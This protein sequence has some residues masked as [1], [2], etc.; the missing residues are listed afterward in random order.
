MQTD[1]S[2][3]KSK[4]DTEHRKA[5]ESHHE[6]RTKENHHE[7]K[8]S[9]KADEGHDKADRK[10]PKEHSTRDSHGHRV[11]HHGLHIPSGTDPLQDDKTSRSSKTSHK[12]HAEKKSARSPQASHHR[13]VGKMG[14]DE[15]QD[16]MTFL[17]E[18]ARQ[19]SSR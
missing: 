5:K 1:A 3:R 2:E 13:K 17:I 18:R 6:S 12:E 14:G 8:R 15:V 7:N 11:I 16:R 10:K 4:H 9:E 19:Q